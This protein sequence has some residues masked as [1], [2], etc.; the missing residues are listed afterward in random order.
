MRFEELSPGARAEAAGAAA[1]YLLVHDYVSLAEACAVH[2][3]SL[4]ELWDE[5]MAAAG[6]PA[7]DV[8]VFTPVL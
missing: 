6:L 5:I 3:C 2:A 1:R 4:Q 8:P 7:C